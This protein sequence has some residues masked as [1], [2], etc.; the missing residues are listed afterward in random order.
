[1]VSETN[2]RIFVDD[3]HIQQFVRAGKVD[4][5]D[6][7]IAKAADEFLDRYFPMQPISTTTI[8]DWKSL[9]STM[10]PWNNVS[11]DEAYQWAKSTIAGQSTHGLLLFAADQPCIIGE[12]EF[13]IKNLD[14][15]VWKAPGPRVLYGVYRSDN[16]TV[17]FT[18]G[19]IEFNGK[20]E[21]FATVEI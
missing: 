2:K 15:L 13:M 3:P 9:P 12:F 4:L 10:L 19:I 6:I 17:R 1:M 14:E 11:D 21:L 5:L 8:I 16:C 18:R 7:N 20:G